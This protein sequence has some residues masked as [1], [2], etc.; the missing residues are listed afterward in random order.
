MG[1]RN[2]SECMRDLEAKGWLRRVDVEIDARLEAGVIQRRAYH[3]GGPALLFTRVKGCRFPM[4]ANLFGTLER[5]R[6]I[7]RDALPMVERLMKAKADPA[8]ALKEALRKPWLYAGAPK[9]LYKALPR[10]VRSGPVLAHEARVSD[11]PQLV[12]WPM[13][14]GAYVTLPQVYSE[15]LAKPGFG[16]SNL[17]MYRVQLSGKA[18]EPDRE[19]GLH[20]QIHRGIG[21]HHGEAIAAGRPLPVNV[22]VGGPPSM[23][24]AAVMPLPEGIAELLFAG[25]LGGRRVD[26][27]DG[28]RSPNGLPI[29]AQA[30]FCICGVVER[31]EKLEGPFGDHLGYYSLAHD[32]PVLKVRKVFHR[33]GAVWPFTT[34][35]RPPQ[36]D[37]VFGTFI[38]ELTA[39]L[40]P[41]VFSGVHEVHAV[42]AAGVHP[43][44][45]AIGSERYVPFAAERQPQELLTNAMSLLGN[46][47]TALSKYVLMAAKE[48]NP[49]S[50]HDMPGFIR[51]LL[52]RM[53][54]AR[55]FHF[56]TRTTMDTL[57]YSGI[58][59][60]Q[61]SKLVLAACGPKKR[62][63]AREL[64]QGFSL[65]EGFRDARV[66]A[67][68]I[69]VL[70]APKHDRGRDEHDPRMEALAKHLGGVGGLEGFP[71]V[72]ACDD[73][74]FTA[75]D[76]DNFLWV[77]F[78]RS[79][80]ATD[81][82]G[83]GGFVHCK[84]WGC[85]GPAV[86]DARLKTYQAPPLEPDPQVEK[87]VDALGAPG[88][89]LHG[90]V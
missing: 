78:T 79:D 46:T 44:L 52:E 37:T 10:K 66:F 57:D 31:G 24:L 22:F 32:F 47:Q 15:S 69:V 2:L 6:Y 26:M 5:T 39:A 4:L 62:E 12:S 63:L 23:T 86:I 48:D 7:F 73:A 77:T 87:R 49:P 85:K 11:L 80:P 68:G 55:D 83:A 19:V 60:N 45:L 64:P 88:G 8:G 20:Y 3:T 51:H 41:T 54:L 16:G 14:G 58:S 53:D 13:D 74:A 1:Y 38:H 42:D 59:L 43:L 71:W 28:S 17:G 35:G 82:Y 84:H 29:L 61:G 72:V 18:Y 90:L 76:W 25:A 21:H 9:A 40:V 67:P 89:P 30:D 81:I 50:T 27:I 65:P 56:I 75:R 36:E 33:P 34:V 70:S